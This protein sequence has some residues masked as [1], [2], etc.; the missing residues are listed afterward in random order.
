MTRA[1]CKMTVVT[2][3]VPLMN[4]A[5]LSEVPVSEKRELKKNNPRW[6]KN[7]K[8]K[9]NS[10]AWS[11]CNGH[12]D[13]AILLTA[14]FGFCNYLLSL[15]FQEGNG[16]DFPTTMWVS[17]LSVDPEKGSGPMDLGVVI[18]QLE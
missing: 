2:V 1:A 7:N 17:C 5:F 12:P 4:D 3:L 6:K 13:P 16:G 14:Y 8:T 18:R 9:Q 15:Q 10:R 11:P